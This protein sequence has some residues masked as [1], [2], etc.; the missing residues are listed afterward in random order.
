MY[1]PF[2]YA[3]RHELLAVRA[4]L[5]DP[6]DLGRFV[7]I[8]EPVKA[9]VREL[10]RCL[11]ACDESGLRTVV[12]INPTLH[13]L[14]TPA[15][16]AAWRASM[17]EV[18]E[19]YPSVVPAFQTSDRTSG[20]ELRAALRVFP[21]R[22]VAVVHKGAGLSDADVGRLV[23]DA[24]VAWH[25][26]VESAVPARQQA[27]LPPPK[28]VGVRD[29]FQKLVRNADYEGQ[30]FFTDRHRT[31]PPAAG[32]G[33]Y[34]C[35]G[36]AFQ[37]GGGKPAAVAI[38]AVFK[39]PRNGDIWVEHFLSDERDIDEGDPGSKFVEAAR[40]LVTAARRRPGEFGTNQ[41]LDAYRE[42]VR[43]SSF[44]G[45]G[46]NKEYQMIHHFCLVLDVLS[47]AL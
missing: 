7:P 40:H 17:E 35:L 26:V 9:S 41:A 34:G 28:K 43:T 27:L 31:Y 47:G 36:A 22:N 21:R 44:P 42:C 19:Q 46:K 11:A 3:R 39:H 29:A 6:R 14:S 4:M 32:F 8:F 37:V 30:Q 12:I 25:I 45:L 1:F 33:D 15:S 23:D 38:H 2:L 13:E 10:V 20:V 16:Q 5:D 18:L 24:R